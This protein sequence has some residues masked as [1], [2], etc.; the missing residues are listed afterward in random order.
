MTTIQKLSLLC[1]AFSI[2]VAGYC[3]FSAKKYRWKGWLKIVLANIFAAGL[4]LFIFYYS[5]I[6]R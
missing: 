3:F 4:N 1:A 2:G 6:M 5:F